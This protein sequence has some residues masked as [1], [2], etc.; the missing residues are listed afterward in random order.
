MKGIIYY[1]CIGAWLLAGM[2]AT[3]VTA[4]ESYGFRVYLKDKAGSPYSTEEPE[5]FLSGESVRLRMAKNKAVTE[6]DLPVSPAYIEALTT[7][8]TTPIATSRWMNTV[9]VIAPDSLV[10]C[11]LS[12][13]PMV[14]SVK[15]VWKGDRDNNLCE[16]NQT[17]R[18]E[19]DE[20]AL[21]SPYGYAD[22]QIRMHNGNKLHDK[23]FRGE[24]M[25]VAV[26]DAGFE[27]A[28]HITV[29]DSLRLLGTHNVLNPER[30]VFEDDEHGTKVLSCM[31][32]NAPGIMVGTAPDASYLLIKSEDRRTEYPIEE[33]YWVA[34]IEYADSVGVDVITSS[35]G[36]FEFD[37]D[38]LS[39]TPD[40]LDGRT[41]F[42]SRAASQVADRGIL[43]FSS[44]GNEG[45]GTWEKISFPA[46]VA[47]LLTV[48][49]I[50]EKKQRSS[51]SSIGPAAD[52]RIKPDV[53]ALGT[54]C[55]VIDEFG[56]V[57]YSNGTSF[58]TP[59]LAGLGVCLWQALPT[60][61]NTEIMDLLR[62]SASHYKKPTAELGHGLPDIYKAYKIGNRYVAGH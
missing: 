6:S 18:L 25:R 4:A 48:G 24:G 33:D 27:N 55:C 44:A 35:L 16:R 31:A 30:T 47:T 42:I 56:A 58:S 52:G 45:S 40:D 51:F 19:P 38:E 57:S 29:F 7:E 8:G 36:Y 21:K 17:G 34:A 10:A 46:D 13:L 9:V 32:A 26:I 3:P 1:I 39:Y 28:D 49:S 14:D 5:A 50:T 11:R 23:G 15:W 54:G 43:L 2:P 53:V 41:A 12:S 37:V 20:P 61:T 62:E 59:I 60:L 22:R